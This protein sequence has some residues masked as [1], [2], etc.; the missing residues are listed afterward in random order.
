MQRKA[1]LCLTIAQRRAIGIWGESIVPYCINQY[2]HVDKTFSFEKARSA[3]STFDYEMTEH[4]FFSSGERRRWLLQIKVTLGSRIPTEGKFGAYPACVE[5]LRRYAGFATSKR[6]EW[7][8]A[9]AN[10]SLRKIF[11]FDG[12][13]VQAILAT[14][15]SRSPL[16]DR[17]DIEYRNNRFAVSIPSDLVEDGLTRYG[18]LFLDG[19]CG[20]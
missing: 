10:L 15:R 8:L 1:K 18:E 7:R 6:R 11:V 4:D 13:D 17:I 14:L 9:V 12:G 3:Y 16:Y 19:E 20:A 5:D 2:P